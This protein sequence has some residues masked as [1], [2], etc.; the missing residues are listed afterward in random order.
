MSSRLQPPGNRVLVLDDDERWCEILREIFTSHGVDI[1]CTMTVQE[2]LKLAIDKADE[3]GLIILDVILHEG[4]T[5]GI[6]VAEQLDKEPATC[7]IPKVF[8]TIV[9]SDLVEKESPHRAA[10]VFEKPLDLG[11]FVEECLKILRSRD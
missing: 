2:C 4:P 9:G 10:G 5:A 8:L 3:Y 7:R 6:S 1:D 11:R